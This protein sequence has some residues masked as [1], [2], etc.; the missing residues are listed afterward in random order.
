MPPVINLNKCTG[1]KGKEYQI[2]VEHCVTDVFLGSEQ[3]K[4]PII[5]YPDECFHENACVLDCPVQAITL[6]IP[7]EMTVVYK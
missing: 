1:C 4:P 5:K 7:L 6:R 3:G 2:C